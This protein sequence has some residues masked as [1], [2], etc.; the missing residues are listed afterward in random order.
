MRRSTAKVYGNS[1]IKG[2]GSNDQPTDG[3]L[4]LRPVQAPGVEVIAH[5]LVVT[6]R[7]RNSDAPCPMLPWR[8]LF[9][10]GNGGAK[11]AMTRACAL[12]WRPLL[13]DLLPLRVEHVEVEVS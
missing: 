9:P 3:V 12:R 10:E 5:F 4:P 11:F 7:P 8:E 13:R 2:E 1:K 6:L